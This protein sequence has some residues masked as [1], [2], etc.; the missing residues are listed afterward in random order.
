MIS[1][2]SIVLNG[3]SLFLMVLAMKT[4]V[5]PYGVF[6]HFVWPFEVRLI[7]DF[8]QDL[9]YWLS[10]YRFNHL[11]SRKPKL[12]SKIPLGFV[13]IVSVR[14][15]ILPVLRD[16]LSLSFPFLLIFLNSLIFV[17]T[18]HKPTYI[19]YWLLGQGLSQIML[20]RQADLKSPYSHVI[21]IP[22]DLIE[23]LPVSI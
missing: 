18:I 22:V 21:K 10:E 12:P 14:L 7:L 8:L 6:S 4:L 9:M 3:M 1:Q 13:I 16:N 20:G 5:T 17:N 11:R 19:P 15:E 2:S 23:H